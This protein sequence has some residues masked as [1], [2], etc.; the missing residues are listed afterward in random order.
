MLPSPIGAC[1]DFVQICTLYTAKNAF[2][3]THG[4]TSFTTHPTAHVHLC[5]L[6]HR[7][8]TRH[9][10]L[11]HPP[12]EDVHTEGFTSS[13]SPSITAGV[14]VGMPI[15]PDHL[16]VQNEEA[17]Q[18]HMAKLPS[19]INGSMLFQ[20]PPVKRLYRNNYWGK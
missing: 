7:I 19:F 8:K 1:E 11:S 18:M 20:F 13:F 15:N 9:L 3:E 16:A 14:Y 10:M 4:Q 5:H 6:S 2:T 12:M 17:Q